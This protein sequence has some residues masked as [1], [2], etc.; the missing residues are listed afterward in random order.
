MPPSLHRPPWVASL[1]SAALLGSALGPTPAAATA[2]VRLGDG[3]LADRSP[4][5]VEGRVLALAA[6]PGELPAIDYQ[7]EV[8]RTIRGPAMG[9]LVV[10]VPGGVRADGVGLAIPGAPKFRP[11]DEVL[12]FLRP[13]GDGTFA[14]QQLLLGAFRIERDGPRRIARRDLAGGHEM[15]LPGRSGVAPLPAEAPRDLAAFRRWLA[16][17]RRG[18]RLPQDYFLPPSAEAPA[19]RSNERFAPFVTGFEPPP[20]GCGE[21]GGHSVR[22]FEFD[23]AGRVG[24][25]AFFR[26]QDGLAGGGFEEFQGALGVWSRDPNTSIR[27][28]FD[29]LT[30]RRFGFTRSDA[31]N[32][33]LFG[34]PNDEISGTFEEGGLLAIGGHWFFCGLEEHDGEQ[35]HRI[36]EGD[37]VLQDGLERFF[38]SLPDPSAAAEE[39]FAH[40]LGHS[41]GLAHT[42]DPEALMFATLHADGRG[43]ALAVDDLAGVHYLYGTAPLSPP[44]A[45][46]GLVARLSSEAGV[47]LTW[48][49][50]SGNES[51][52]HVERRDG[53]GLFRLLR[54]VAADTTQLVDAGVDPETEY[55]Y[56]VRSVNAAGASPAS[57]EVTVTTPANPWP[58]APSN[59][60]AAP[61]SSR[62]IRLSWQNNA[63]DG[64]EV[65]L[66]LVLGGVPLEIPGT[67][68]AADIRSVIVDGLEPG[69]HYTF[70]VAARNAFGESP[71]SDPAGAATFPA[72]A[73]CAVSSRE[74]CLLAGRFQVAVRFRNQHAGTG[75]E[76]ATAV[77][78]TDKTGLF[79]FFGPGNTE[80]IVKMLDGRSINGHFWVFY[81]AL[82]DVEYWLEITDTS[83]GE[84][85]IYHNPPGEI[86]GFADT[87]A[88]S[89]ST[90]GQGAAE[91]DRRVRVDPASF[92]VVA[93]PPAESLR[94]TASEPGSCVPGPRTL[95]LLRDRVQV[96][97][98]FR[99]PGEETQ[100]PARARIGSDNTGTF[101]FFGSQNTE[102]VVKALD[103][104]GWN[105]HLWL[106]YGALSNLEY[107]LTVT[108]TLTGQARLYQN[109][110]GQVCGGVDLEAFD[111]SVP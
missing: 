97:V 100:I 101:W 15:D 30:G 34:D 111:V 73:Q 59:L 87:E 3:A 70:R 109:P 13:R 2:F 58:H 22:W 107:T 33:V 5:I 17:R 56:R 79:W 39:L 78:A 63:N 6:A 105:G 18:E 93:A 7:I 66:Y 103:G 65:V 108:D 77:P 31:T 90:A 26:G 40:E 67:G 4:V 104:S 71:L 80:L 94:N 43:G 48:S 89:D 98:T 74:L 11:G 91:Q 49:D 81:G 57:G 92:T 82:S 106:F 12:L 24:W 47:D 45:P 54:T 37:I 85:Q 102:L 36:I 9:S 38:A 68:I 32:V 10:R 96:E 76:D 53:G 44:A 83:T 88:F 35:L 51:L 19:G 95:C 86:C 62:E 50:R 23:T 110:E 25:R 69:V 27:Y 52:F 29:G 99:L 20:A 61:L 72:G 60:W 64:A 16:A 55:T 8:E 21:N 14:L 42:L 1:L 75:A 46:T 41:L 28:G 84:V